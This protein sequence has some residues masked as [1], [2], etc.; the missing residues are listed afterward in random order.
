[1][2]DHERSSTKHQRYSHLGQSGNVRR[3][4]KSAHFALK[5]GFVFIIHSLFHVFP[6]PPTRTRLTCTFFL[7][8]LIFFSIL[9]LFVL[10]VI[11]IYRQKTVI[12]IVINLWTALIVTTRMIILM[13]RQFVPPE[14][15]VHHNWIGEDAVVAIL[16][17]RSVNVW[18]TIVIK[19]KITVHT[20][21][22]PALGFSYEGSSLD[23]TWSS[24]DDAYPQSWRA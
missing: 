12:L 14:R 11:Y 18:L 22:G 8:F 24:Q 7:R 10:G 17:Q 9:T 4:G 3:T 16:N 15:N 19:L 13:G 1:M 20:I 5:T 21:I 6:G 2:A 23:F